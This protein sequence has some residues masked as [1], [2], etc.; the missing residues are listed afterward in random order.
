MTFILQLEI[1]SKVRY[2]FKHFSTV[3]EPFSIHYYS[4][5]WYFKHKILQYSH[6]KVITD[7]FDVTMRFSILKNLKM[8]DKEID[9]WNLPFLK[10][11]CSVICKSHIEF[12]VRRDPP[13][14]S[15][16]KP[17]ERTR[18]DFV[19]I[20]VF[21]RCWVFYQT[22]YCLRMRTK[23]YVTKKKEIKTA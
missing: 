15:V 20:N 5:L 3:Y 18:L 11:T 21:S 23:R 1:F 2:Y 22:Q 10:R 4:F 13:G 8:K 9:T 19:T 12:P 17:L 14:Q 16:Y 6:S 7:N